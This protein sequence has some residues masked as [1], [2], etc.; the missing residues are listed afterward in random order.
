MKSALQTKIDELRARE[1]T[2]SS[3]HTTNCN[4]RKE[5]IATLESREKSLVL[6][7]ST[8]QTCLDR[9]VKKSETLSHI[10]EGQISRLETLN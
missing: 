10:V 1:A 5:Q 2:S 4:A 7:V 8:H 9:I 6:R 3:S